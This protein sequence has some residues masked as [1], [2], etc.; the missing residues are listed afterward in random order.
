MNE[1]FN[2]INNRFSLR[3]Y[4]DK[5]ITEEDLNLIL[6]GAMRAPT[7]GNM[8]N[9]SILVVKDEE[10][11]KKLSVTCDN[12]PFIAK[13]SVVLIFLADMERLYNYFQL[14]E[15]DQFC[16]RNGE[17][18]KEPGLANLF[19]SSS[20]ALIAAQNAVITAESLGIGSC[21]I[22]DIVE[23]YEVHKELLNLPDR[24]FPIAMLTLGHFPEDIKRIRKPRFNKQFIVFDEEYRKLES[25]ELQ[26]MYQDLEEK[27]VPKNT[28]GAKNYGQLLYRRKFGTEFFEEMDRSIQLILKHWKGEA[29]R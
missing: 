29:L 17:Q 7:A 24:V 19:L 26:E 20:D 23:N 15:V 13:A 8:M 21:Y 28:Y 18:F 5:P 14:C 25:S 6:E 10:K 22:G 1:V 4:A 2:L 9:Y 3:R 16:K 12:Q 11:K 27:Q